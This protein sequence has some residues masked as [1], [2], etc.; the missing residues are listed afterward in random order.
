MPG[1]KELFKGIDTDGSGTITVDELR[2]ALSHWGHKISA[3]EL[4]ELMR[5]ADVDGNGIIDYNEF[6]AAT[7]HLSKLEKEEV[8]QKTFADFDKDGN[9]RISE[10]ELREAL[11]SF[12]I[13]NDDVHDLIVSADKDNDG[14]IDYQEFLHLMRNT[15]DSESNTRGLKF[16]NFNVSEADSVGG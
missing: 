14:Y 4:E 7:M 13:E 6:V 2:K 8:M 12:G 11:A 1:L 3:I 5:F 15:D 9:G 10:D 16:L